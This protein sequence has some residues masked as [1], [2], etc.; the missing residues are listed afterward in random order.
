MSLRRLPKEEYRDI[1]ADDFFA[2]F[3]VHDPSASLHGFIALHRASN[4]RPAFGATR[5]W[6]YSDPQIALREA[7]QLSQLMSRKAAAASLPYGGGKAVLLES[8]FSVV[9][10][11]AYFAR[12]V[13]FINELSGQFITGADVGVNLSDVLAMKKES[14]YIV[15]TLHDPVKHT[16]QGL[17]AGLGS[18]LEFVFGS[19]SLSNRTIAIQGLGK[20]GGGFLEYIYPQTKRVYVADVNQDVVAYYKN[21]FPEIEAVPPDLIHAQKVDV[22]SPCAMSFSL[23]EKTVPELLCRAVV[24]GANNQ[25][26]DIALAANLQKRKIVVAPDYVVNGGGLISVVAEY[27]DV[28]KNE[29]VLSGR[30][31]KIGSTVKHLLAQSKQKDI[32]PVILAEEWVRDTIDIRGWSE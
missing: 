16:I 6:H 22:F 9:D 13:E 31:E 5:L 1:I 18:V 21:K 10:R 32:S 29:E 8:D 25:F 20:I 24:G 28:L 27:D 11:D 14:D 30:I 2:V 7:L 12:Y 17:V 15:G 19:N 3:E 4:E 26:S 23:N